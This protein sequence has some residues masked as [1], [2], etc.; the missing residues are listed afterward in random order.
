[1]K[2]TYLINHFRGMN[3]KKTFPIEFLEGKKPNTGNVMNVRTN[4]I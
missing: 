4:E 3:L 2:F 1:M